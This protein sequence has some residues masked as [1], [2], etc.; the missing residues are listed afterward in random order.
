[1]SCE[2]VSDLDLDESRKIGYTYKCLGS[3]FWAL[4]QKNF[5]TAIQTLVMEVR[6]FRLKTNFYKCSVF[7][8]R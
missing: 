7:V 5:R 8:G 3:G 1:M 6:G 4:K 2:N